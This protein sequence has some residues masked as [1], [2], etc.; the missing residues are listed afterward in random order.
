[1]AT[2]KNLSF[3]IAALV[4]V[5]VLGF[6][7]YKVFKKDGKPEGAPQAPPAVPQP[8]N[9][10]PPNNIPPVA[11]SIP[12]KLYIDSS[13][14]QETPSM[15]QYI[16]LETTPKIDEAVSRANVTPILKPINPEEVQFIR[17]EASDEESGEES[18]EEE[19]SSEDIEREEITEF[20]SKTSFEPL[21]I[22]ELGNYKKNFPGYSPMVMCMRFLLSSSTLSN[23]MSDNHFN[24]DTKPFFQLLKIIAERGSEEEITEA[25]ATAEKK[26]PVRSIHSFN[27]MMD[28][29][30]RILSEEDERVC[31]IF[32]NELHFLS[33][34]DKSVQAK[35]VAYTVDLNNALGIIIKEADRIERICNGSLWKNARLQV[36]FSEL[37]SSVT[38]TKYSD[39]IV[40]TADRFIQKMR[41]IN[42]E[43]QTELF[44]QNTGP[45]K[46]RYLLKS[47]IF[48]TK[49]D[50]R[51]PTDHFIEFDIHWL[52][53]FDENTKNEWIRKLLTNA[54]SLLYERE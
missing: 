42:I 54:I 47:V 35:N 43:H 17:R 36:R 37:R 9:I 16:P 41:E 26:Y 33:P 5:V 48:Q 44:F 11:Q 31:S 18:D 1:M 46:T 14:E 34:V 7:T 12:E 28:F 51:F 6:G 15:P 52:N 23:L 20:F 13:E 40:I 2:I 8:K 53:V 21:G 39:V 32:C 3:G 38:K 24:S 25:V 49:S 22:N 45:E 10:V 4:T 19:R 30:I 50:S 29:V 27:G